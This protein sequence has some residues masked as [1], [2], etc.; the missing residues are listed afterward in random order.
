MT[1]S[2]LNELYLHRMTYY[3]LAKQMTTGSVNYGLVLCFQI[4]RQPH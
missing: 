1:K 3:A 2:L 4:A